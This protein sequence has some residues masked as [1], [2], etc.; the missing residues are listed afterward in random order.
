MFLKPQPSKRDTATKS[1]WMLEPLSLSLALSAALPSLGYSNNFEVAWKLNILME[2][3]LHQLI[4][5]LSHYLQGFI[6]PRWCRISSINSI[7]CRQWFNYF[8][9]LVFHL[10]A[11]RSWQP[12][13]QYYSIIWMSRYVNQD[14]VLCRSREVHKVSEQWIKTTDQSETSCR[15]WFMLH[16]CISFRNKQLRKKYS[17]IKEL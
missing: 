10:F 6:H 5:S 8:S 13:C 1:R 17:T 12:N 7:I 16:N 11:V 3:I 14:A 15:K 4:G 2:E 9:D